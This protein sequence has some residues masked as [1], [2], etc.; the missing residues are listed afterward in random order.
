MNTIHFDY[1]DDQ[2]DKV[3][4]FLDKIDSQCLLDILKDHRGDTIHNILDDI[5]N[6]YREEWEGYKNPG[7]G[8]MFDAIDGYEMERY[9]EK[10]FDVQF[11]EV[12]KIVLTN[13]NLQGGKNNA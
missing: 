10:R 11:K 9:F 3:I 12:S 6:R 8:D 1:W 7:D 2:Q 5:E 13:K 4:E